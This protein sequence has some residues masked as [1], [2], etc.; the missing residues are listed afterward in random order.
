[1]AKNTFMFLWKYY[2]CPYCYDG[3]SAGMKANWIKQ[4]MWACACQG[5]PL[6]IQA[7]E[8]WSCN[9]RFWASQEH[10][11]SSLE[12]WE[13]YIAECPSDLP[14]GDIIYDGDTLCQVGLKL[15]DDKILNK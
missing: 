13:E 3:S 1:M 10:Q 2:F 7:V 11:K 5:K 14:D 4:K 9:K 15:P 8:C 6:I 12:G